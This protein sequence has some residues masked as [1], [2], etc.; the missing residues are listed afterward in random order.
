MVDIIPLFSVSDYY[1]ADRFITNKDG[2]WKVSAIQFEL[3]PLLELCSMSVLLD[4][5]YL[6]LVQS[7][8]VHA[9]KKIEYCS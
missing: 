8:P 3:D 9:A 1:D 2:L 4:R 6:L 7:E 5:I